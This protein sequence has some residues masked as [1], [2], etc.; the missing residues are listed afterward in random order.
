MRKMYNVQTFSGL[1][2]LLITKSKFKPLRCIN[3]PMN[4]DT[5]CSQLT[6]LLFSIL[7]ISCCALYAFW[8]CECVNEHV[9]VPSWKI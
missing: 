1:N 4:Q 9:V 3:K 7:E 8:L 2:Q 6:V 5:Q